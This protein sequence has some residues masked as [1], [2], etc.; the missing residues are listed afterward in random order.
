[1]GQIVLCIGP[2]GTGKS[3]SLRNLK[4]EECLVFNTA[5]KL[6]PFK[7]DLSCVNL[8]DK[9]GTERYETIKSYIQ[10]L[11]VNE[12]RCKLYIVDDAQFLMAFELMSR[13]NKGI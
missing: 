8:R 5:N 3:A 11:S 2:S 10:S 7:S 1:M 13:A 4:K 6:M 12:D 9:N